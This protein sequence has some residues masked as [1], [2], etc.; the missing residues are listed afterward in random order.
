MYA[1]RKFSVGN[2]SKKSILQHNDGDG[3]IAFVVL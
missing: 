2:V 3:L 1:I